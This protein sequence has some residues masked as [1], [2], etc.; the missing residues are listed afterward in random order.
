MSASGSERGLEG[1][2]CRV[3]TGQACD[4]AGA[5]QKRT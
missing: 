2:A 1:P 3:V 5:V 4:A